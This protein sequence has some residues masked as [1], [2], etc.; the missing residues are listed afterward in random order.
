[1][2]R[3]LCFIAPSSNMGTEKDDIIFFAMSQDVVE[4][5][6]SQGNV[7][8]LSSNGSFSSFSFGDDVIRFATPSSLRRYLGVKRWDNG[9]IEVEA[10]YG[11]GVEEDYI[12]LVP[13][14][15]NLYYDVAHF[16]KPIKKVEV[17]Y[18]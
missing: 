7:A 3:D 12:D 14:L 13:I 6:E 17:R 1:M 9:Y 2:G 10:D 8:V 16:L 11:H 4:K 5:M 15:R 18:A